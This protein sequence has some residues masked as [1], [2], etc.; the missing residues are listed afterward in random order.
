VTDVVALD[1]GRA[2]GPSEAR[3]L[4]DQVKRDVQ[5]LWTKLVRL[6]EGEA[7]TASGMRPGRL[8]WPLSLA[9]ASRRPTAYSTPAAS[10]RL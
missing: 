2:L 7:H 6:Y 9:W 4:T 3:R 10:S 5:E 8:T 1:A